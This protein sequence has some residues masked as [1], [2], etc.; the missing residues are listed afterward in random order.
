M[1]K[2]GKK[3]WLADDNWQDHAQ[4]RGWAWDDYNDDYAAER[5]SFPIYMNMIRWVQEQP[6]GN[7]K[8]PF[9]GSPSIYSV[10]DVD[11]PVNF[12]PDTTRKSFYVHRSL[13]Q[14]LFEVTE[15]KEEHK[16]QYTPF[17]TDGLASA[18]LLLK[19]TA[20]TLRE[21]DILAH[22]FPATGR[23]SGRGRSIRCSVR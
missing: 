13:N 23:C 14:N 21:Y 20:G 3:I 2:T 19:D 5:S 16:E 4:G 17:I 22:S 10:P 11:W 9:G 15:G 7:T 18:A 1:R 12:N 6:K 8:D